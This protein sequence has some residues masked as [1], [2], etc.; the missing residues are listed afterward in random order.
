VADQVQGQPPA[1]GQQPAQGGGRGNQPPPP[2]P[3]DP[4]FHWPATRTVVG[5]SV[6]RL[7]GPEKVTGRAKYT[8]DIARPGMLYGRVV[9]SPHVHARVVS[10]DLSAARRAP[11]VKAA[12]VLR[13]PG[14]S[15]EYQITLDAEGGGER[16]TV[17]VETE[18]GCDSAVAARIRRELHDLLALSPEV[19]LCAMGT[20]E[21]PQGKAIRVVDRR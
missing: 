20:I 6:K 17:L 13:Q 15:H 4:R 19:R 7:D 10:V 5:T 12:I 21:R 14:V 8:F 2:P 11:G 18:P 3:A 1:Q 16:M 9:R